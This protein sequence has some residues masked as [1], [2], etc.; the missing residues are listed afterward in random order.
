[1][2]VS[3][4]FINGQRAVL[5]C[6]ASIVLCAGIVAS[7]VA[8]DGPARTDAAVKKMEPPKQ[9]GSFLIKFEASAGDAKIDEVAEY[10]GANKV[11]ALSNSESS[12]HKDP[13]RWRKLRFDAVDDVK[14][15]AR[16]IFQ[17]MRVDE[18]DEV[19]VGK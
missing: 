16:R 7:T 3:Q 5:M 14:D 19:T 15:I 8:A 2:E 18:V 6:V 13:E 11:L 4:T 17:D 9:S 12:T 10:Y 1:M